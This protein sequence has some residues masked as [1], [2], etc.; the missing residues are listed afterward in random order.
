MVESP[1]SYERILTLKEQGIYQWINRQIQNCGDRITGWRKEIQGATRETKGEMY[2]HFS[3]QSGYNL[4]LIGAESHAI[5]FQDRQTRERIKEENKGKGVLYLSPD[6]SSPYKVPLGLDPQYPE[7]MSFSLVGQFVLKENGREAAEGKKL[8]TVSVV[9]VLRDGWY[10]RAIFSPSSTS[11]AAHPD[12]FEK[13]QREPEID[14]IGELLRKVLLDKDGGLFFSSILLENFDQLFQSI[15]AGRALE[16][17]ICQYFLNGTFRENLKYP[18]SNLIIDFRFRTNL[19]PQDRN[20]LDNLRRLERT[21][22]RCLL[23]EVIGVEVSDSASD[24]Q[25]TQI[26]NSSVVKEAIRGSVNEKQLISFLQDK[27]KFL[28][29]SWIGRAIMKAGAD[30]FVLGE[31]EEEVIGREKE[32]FYPMLLIYH[33]LRLGVMCR[34]VTNEVASLKLT[35]RDIDRKEGEIDKRLAKKKAKVHSDFLEHIETLEAEAKRG[36]MPE[37]LAERWLLATDILRDDKHEGL[38]LSEFPLFSEVLGHAIDVYNKKMVEIL[39]KGYQ[40]AGEPFNLPEDFKVEKDPRIFSSLPF[41][42]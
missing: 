26:V 13:Y 39:A 11:T 34:L 32:I 22:E 16:K 33:T 19:I 36:T 37:E 31:S 25:I 23:E 18:D 20:D 8:Q 42:T 29:V 5:L 30:G 12:K 14:P 7:G 17:E 3:T 10:K 24:D 41:Q 40:F 38:P 35:V 27:R 1:F 2:L 9:D 15:V 21:Y 28:K 4:C 6:A